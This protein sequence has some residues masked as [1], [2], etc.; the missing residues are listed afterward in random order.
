VVLRV[1]PDEEQV[2]DE[3]DNSVAVVEA[4]TEL[5]VAEVELSE[6]AVEDSSVVVGSALW[7]V[8]EAL[9]E[10]LVVAS[11]MAGLD[12]TLVVVEEGGGGGGGGGELVEGASSVTVCVVTIVTG[13]VVV[14]VVGDSGATTEMSVLVMVFVVSFWVVFV[15]VTSGVSVGD[16]VTVCTTVVVLPGSGDVALPPSIGTIE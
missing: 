1:D 16:D 2:V 9:E 8:C 14:R 15:T 4:A 3:G 12:G 10:A 7:V 5:S 13:A 6:D 11:D